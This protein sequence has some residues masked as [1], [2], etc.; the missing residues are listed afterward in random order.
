MD[1]RFFFKA[2]AG[3][4]LGGI[5]LFNIACAGDTAQMDAPVADKAAAGSRRLEKIGVQLY[6]LRSLMEN[7]V[8]GTLEA[9]AATG[10]N[11]VEFAG[12]FDHSPA[13]IRALIDRLGLAAPAVHIGL[14]ALRG[15]LDAQ[16]AAAEVVGHQFIVCP[17]LDPAERN[18]AG[19]RQ[20]IVDLNRIGAV[21][22][23]RGL[24]FAY[25]NHDF[26]F[27][28][29]DGQL[30]F[31]MI[32]KETD[33]DLVSIEL[34]LY[35]ITMGGYDPLAYF[36]KYPGRFKLCHVKD[37]ADMA[38]A[39]G[40]AAVGDGEMDFGR[41]FAQSKQAG[42]EHYFV[43]HDNAADPVVSIQTSYKTL[44]ALRF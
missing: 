15:D 41:I 8:P 39:R 6:T 43:E 37:M 7:D 38:G 40:M 1:R 34:D 3:V 23:E 16:L 9:V 11:E 30:P 36:E 24:Q 2:S 20:L 21:C 4:A 10:Y 19:Y 27:A 44:S 32:L 14:P 33:P 42:L 35:W 13:D 22:K 26:E 17:W 28:D 18:A 5:S 12:Y 31:D 25:H 29:M